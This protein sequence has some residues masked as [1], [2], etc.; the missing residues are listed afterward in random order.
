MS[1][2]KLREKLDELDLEIVKLFEERMNISKKIGIYKNIKDLPIRDRER[3]NKIINNLE[4]RVDEDIKFAVEPLYEKIFQLSKEYQL[5]IINNSKYY[6]KKYY[7]LIGKSL[8]HS[9][10]PKIHKALAGYDYNLYPMDKYELESFL[11][12]RQFAGMNV[13]IPYKVEVIKYLDEMSSLAN[14]IGSVNTIVNKKG[15]L[16]GYNTDYYGFKYMI[17][18]AKIEVNGKKVLV[19]GSGGASKT[20]QTYL[21]DEKAAEIVIISRH[22]ENNYDRLDEFKTFNVIINTTPVGMYP[23]NLECNIDL[24][25]FEDCEAVVDII[26]NPLKTKLILNAERR[27]LKTATGLD[28]LVSQAY[29]AAQLFLGEDIPEERIEKTINKIK[30]NMLNIILIGM[31]GCGKS[32]IGKCLSEKLGRKFIDIDEEIEKEMGMSISEIFQKYGEGKFR[33]IEAEITKKYGKDTGIIIATGGGTPIYQGNSNALLQNGYAILL[34][35][36]IKKLA[37]NGR[38][39][40]ADIESLEILCKN[41]C[42]IYKQVASKE[43]FVNEDNIDE[44]LKII[45]EELTKDE[46]ISDKRS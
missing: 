20:V 46:I 45:I 12:R 42:N 22:T 14:E 1:L 11:E 28:M 6:P 37:R 33:K 7:G 32:T 30:Q 41:R 21:R 25:I 35:R 8:E 26:Y 17:E 4:N 16:F 29:Y 31:P 13:T 5:D 34:L 10:S 15:K 19:L 36:D 18:K 40:S 27:G 3:E 2:N 38:P 39:L 9:E 43:I 24:D 23:S 44:T